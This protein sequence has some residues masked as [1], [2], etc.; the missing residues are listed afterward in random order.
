MTGEPALRPDGRQSPAAL[1]LQR[2]VLRHLAALGL[3]GIPE[4][5]L[6]SGRRA[7]IAALDA[8][9]EIAIVEIKSCIADFRA[10]RKWP[11]YRLHCDRLFFAVAPDFP[12]EIL[13]DAVGILVGDAFGAELVRPAPLH[14]LP[15]ATRKALLIRLA[16]AG[17]GRLA[18][19][20]DPDALGLGE[21]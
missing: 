14:P 11:D 20:Y 17:A 4:F 10:D 8:K 13:P 3:V 9:G 6:V 5:G 12:L 16:R 15:A 7:D 1:A 2:G 21:F 19:L 18:R